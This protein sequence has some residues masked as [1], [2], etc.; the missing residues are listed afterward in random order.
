MQVTHQPISTSRS[1][2]ITDTGSISNKEQATKQ[3]TSTQDTHRESDSTNKVIKCRHVNHVDTDAN[4]QNFYKTITNYPS[5][6]GLYG[7]SNKYNNRQKYTSFSKT[8][9]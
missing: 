4:I 5:N 6:S 2:T 3:H 7:V 1:I 9:S 8:L